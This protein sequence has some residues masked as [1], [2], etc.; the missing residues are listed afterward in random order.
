MLVIVFSGS[1]LLLFN[2]F[3]GSEKVSESATLLM[4]IGTGAFVVFGYL[5]QL[6]F[7]RTAYLEGTQR[8]EPKTL[9]TTGA[10]F[11]WR[12]LL[13][14]IIV[15]V[16]IFIASNIIFVCVY[17]V[18]GDGDIDKA[19]IENVPN[20]M[21]YVSVYGA[22]LVFVK[23]IVFMPAIIVTMDCRVRDVMGYLKS[24]RIFKAGEVW[25]WIFLMVLFNAGLYA[26]E[27]LF[28]LEE[29]DNIVVNAGVIFF[30]TLMML[31]VHM[32]AI[33]FIKSEIRISKSQTNPKFQ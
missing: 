26:V 31:G 15:G 1:G 4:G 11:L 33:N 27:K 23:P 16:F 13:A 6:G 20:W 29:Y 5:M 22:M 7:L 32:G 19:A 10:R 9:I 12:V 3:A 14:A 2:E 28:A 24:L 17:S 30:S 8:Q 18:F 21:M 25:G